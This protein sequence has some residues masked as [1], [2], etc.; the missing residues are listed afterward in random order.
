MRLLRVASIALLNLAAVGS[1]FSQVQKQTQPLGMVAKAVKAQVGSADLSEGATV[2]SGDYL[3]T[4]D[5]GSLL[6]RFGTLSLELEPNS[7]AH[8]YRAPYGVVAELDR[9]TAVYST[10]GNQQ[11]LVIVASDVRVTPELTLSDLGSVSIDN[12]CNVTVHSQR[13]QANVSTGTESKLVEEGKAYRVTAENE[14]SY[15]EYVSP[16]TNDYHS[17]HAHKPCAPVKMA[18]GKPPVAAGQSRFLLVTAVVA[19]AATGIAV[20]KAYES[21]SRP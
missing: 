7:A 20:W 9:G 18:K 10:P 11:N 14:V 15:R 16:D 8:V 5:G 2:F 17:Y 19:G 4:G 6:V 21:A 3:S 12:P 1:A 13:G